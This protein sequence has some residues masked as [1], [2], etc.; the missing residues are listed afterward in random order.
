MS[1]CIFCKIAR[2]E[3]PSKKIYENENFFSIH[4]ISPKVKGHCLVISKRHFETI[5]D[6]PP[7]LGVELIDATKNTSLRLM[8]EN[9]SSG[10]NCV[11]NSFES[12]GQVVKHFHMHILPRKEGDNVSVIV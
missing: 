3:I 9:K 8:K 12:S 10:F 5:L 1:E 7:S 4:D 6:M 11:V 2:G